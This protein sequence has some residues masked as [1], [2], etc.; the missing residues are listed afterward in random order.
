MRKLFNE[1]NKTFSYNY[2]D[3][4]NINTLKEMKEKIK[5]KNFLNVFIMQPSFLGFGIDL[6]KLKKY[7]LINK[8]HNN[9]YS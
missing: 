3:K 5:N 2:E 7:F 4:S 9:L 6:I 1:I 8:A